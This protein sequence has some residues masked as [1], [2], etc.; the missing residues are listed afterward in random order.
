MN[1]VEV[2]AITT[3]HFRE[4]PE[5]GNQQNALTLKINLGSL[6]QQNDVY[7]DDIIY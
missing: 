6:G 7:S 3:N 1:E 2:A 5:N 4:R